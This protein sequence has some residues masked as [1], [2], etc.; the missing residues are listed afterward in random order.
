MS[1]KRRKTFLFH[2]TRK[3][4]K[5]LSVFQTLAG[6]AARAPSRTLFYFKIW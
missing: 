3:K 2:L 5:D 4:S 1:H 6:K